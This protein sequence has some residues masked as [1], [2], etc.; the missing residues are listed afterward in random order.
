MQAPSLYRLA[1]VQIPEE[2]PQIWQTLA[3]LTKERARPAFEIMCRE[4]ALALRYKAPRVTHAVEV[5]LLGLHFFTEDPYCV[6]NTVNIFQFPY[7][8]LS[9]GSE[10]SMVTQR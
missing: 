8:S 3:P 2:L 5:I 9:A 10:A 4:S 1:D 6:N 7:L